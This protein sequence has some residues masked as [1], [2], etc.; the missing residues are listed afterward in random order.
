MKRMLEHTL[1]QA[2]T[3]DI[4]SS[5]ISSYGYSLRGQ[6]LILLAVMFEESSYGRGLIG[7]DRLKLTLSK[8]VDRIPSSAPKGPP[9]L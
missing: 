8:V 6:L 2:T 7:R 1:F 4:V 9:E 3:P 5:P